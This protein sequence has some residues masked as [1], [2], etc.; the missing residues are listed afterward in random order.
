MKNNDLFKHM[1]NDKSFRDNVLEHLQNQL[2]QE[3]NKP[4]NN[5]NFVKIEQLTKA[6]CEVARVDE[7]K[8]QQFG[9]FKIE[10]EIKSEQKCKK[11]RPLIIIAT[12][13]IALLIVNLFSLLICD[14][15]I[16]SCILDII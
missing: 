15:N 14:L 16:F 5:R 4:F 8:I 2:N 11:I 9:I 7:D 13:V 3:M 1:V 10:Q 6:V 12:F